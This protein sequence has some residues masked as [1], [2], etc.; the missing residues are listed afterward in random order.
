ME[1]AYFKRALLFNGKFSVSHKLRIVQRGVEPAPG[2][3]LVVIALL[4]DLSVLQHQNEIRVL[5]GGQAVGDDEAGAALH[6]P[7]HGLLDL[8]LRAG[9]HVGGGL[10]Q[11]EHGGVAEHGAGDGDKLPLA[12]GDVH[13]VVGQH[14]VIPVGQMLDVGVDAGGLGGSHHLVHGGAL[15]A[16]GDVFK[17]GAVEQPGVLQHHGVGSAEGVPFDLPDLVSVHV[18]GAVVHVVEPHEQ[19]DDGG[20]ARARGAHDGDGFARPGGDAD[21]PQDGL[22]R[23]SRCRR[24]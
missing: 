13:A 23:R 3:Q 4:G 10:V 22:V 6:Q 9:V 12:L 15:L 8:D 21:F 14:G 7:V 17:D 2:H 20:L 11:N 19:V 16:V 1:K 18:N 5:N 24:G